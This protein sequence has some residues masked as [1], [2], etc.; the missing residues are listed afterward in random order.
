MYKNVNIFNNISKMIYNII[1]FA[2]KLQNK[3]IMLKCIRRKKGDNM[4]LNFSVENYKSFK[5]KISFS[6][7]PA[8]KQKGLDYSVFSSEIGN[9]IIRSLCSSV[10]YGPNASGKTTVIGAMDTMRSLILRGNI[11]NV[12]D[13][14]PNEASYY[15]ELIP[16]NTLK[17]RHPVKFSI[18]FIEN[19]YHIEYSFSINLGL[20][21][22]RKFER[23]IDEEILNINGT[24]IFTRNKN[25]VDVHSPSKLTSLLNVDQKLIDIVNDSLSDTELF[26]TNGFK[27]IISR[28]IAEMII[29]WFEKKFIVIYRANS[30]ELKRNFEED[31]KSGFYIEKM[32][33]DAAKLFGLNSNAIGYVYS[34]EEHKAK[35]CSILDDP[36]TNN[37]A[38]I[39]SKV[40]ESYGTIRFINLFPLV[41]EAIC[42]G[43]TLVIDEF[44]ASLHPMA[45]M[46]II[47]IFHDDEINIHQAQLIF[48]TH[49][50][51]FLN[52]NL[53]RRD[54]IKFVER[55]D[56]NISEL[57][58]LSD[59]KT[60]GKMGV[61]K[62]DDY[63]KN[64]FVSQ[65]G[66]IKDVDF[67]PLFQKLV[68][69]EKNQDGKKKK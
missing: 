26:L 39:S 31:D 51:I 8:A 30:L 48:D 56:D 69:G 63:M 34:D 43:G 13:N 62:S 42:T 67:S 49:N 38:L 36:N 55:N 61:R 23:F 57:Y 65:Y 3:K 10:I 47:N 21:L 5:D 1:Y 40:F 14:R 58:S 27:L 25:Q 66:A 16:N 12:K 50:P 32:T 59:F 15:L 11:L 33:N 64:Y 68:L 18:S 41:L 37:E 28:K 22:E 60:A 6:M 17:Q 52:N 29:G 9:K 45:L 2:K 54:E 20:F 7:I 46:S 44:D 19:E 35:L 53:F 4:L 24:N